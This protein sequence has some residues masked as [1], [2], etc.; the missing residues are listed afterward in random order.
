MN[1]N[2][3]SRLKKELTLFDTFSVS[4]GAMISS[5]FFLLPG[6]ASVHTGA[7]VGLAYL[8]AALL[9]VPAMVSIAELST[10]MPRSGG[11]YF[12]LDRSIGPIL[13][14]IG[15]LG[16][17]IAVVLKTAFALVGI[18]AYTSI[19]VELPLKEVAL[20]LT[21]V[22]TV[23]NIVG[24]KETTGL[25]RILVTILLVILFLFIVK[26]LIN[27]FYFQ[28]P[29]VVRQRF[30]PFFAHGSE[31]LFYTTGLVF[32]SY[33]GLTQV[34]SVAEEVQNPERNIP[35]GMFL[36]LAVTTFVY[37]VG[38][39]VMVAVM[40]PEQF[41]ADLTPVAT[42]GQAFFHWLPPNWSVTLIVIAAVAA[43][44][45]T[46][47]G[48][49]LT[50]SR[51]PFAMAR[52][53][54][55]PNV[56]A[57]IGRFQ[58]PTPSILLT[59][60]L[61]MAFI[62]LLEP[63]GIAKLASAYIL[64][65]F[66]LLNMAVI[67]MRESRIESYDPGYRSPLY[68]WMQI[69]GVIASLALIAFMGL[70]AMLFILGMVALCLVWYFVYARARSTR[71]GAIR[72]WFALLGESRYEGLEQELLSI[73]REKGLRPNDPF[74]EVIARASVID[75]QEE[76]VAF[77]DIVARASK[78]LAHDLPATS[79]ELALGFLE[80][81]RIGVAPI[82][83]GVVIP[84]LRL[85]GMQRTEVVLIRVLSGMKLDVVDVHGDHA[86]D[87]KIHAFI[88][89]VSP[90]QSPK[91]QLRILAHLAEVVDSDEFLPAWLEAETDVEIKEFLLRD[92]R[93]LSLTIQRKTLTETLIGQTLNELRMQE[94]ELMGLLKRGEKTVV[95]QGSVKLRAGDQLTLIANSKLIRKLAAQYQL[96]VPG[97]DEK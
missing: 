78:K 70:F 3:S 34:T 30:S 15:G 38:V 42:A 72:H 96:A 1:I 19:F 20:I 35:L 75:I 71:G 76:G 39:F 89:M 6:L 10:A 91:Q 85:V 37:A 24:A 50:A 60:G 31:G 58:T 23:L 93:F 8:L 63:E 45:S 43:F 9:A 13:G 66:M 2:A 5:G 11:T 84:H 32:V 25:Q 16:T 18:G 56:F 65:I 47:N 53:H 51:Y 74:D 22:F 83:N 49:L 94:G 67:V 41:H 48:G 81:T 88:F 21:L 69:F 80:A 28:D 26:G 73:M 52:D 17:Y 57:K 82:S 95:L 40:E 54:L 29:E 33:L 62:L 87:D 12:F 4:T 77:A 97:E 64:F 61:I 90:E 92:E 14:T 46:A 59:S 44:V 36:A 79:E 86:P 7:S 55:V 68:P 27:A